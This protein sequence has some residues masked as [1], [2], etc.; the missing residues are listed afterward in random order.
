MDDP[1]VPELEDGAHSDGQILPFYVKWWNLT[2]P[3]SS[4]LR[5]KHY[6]ID[7]IV[8]RAVQVRFRCFEKQHTSYTD[9]PFGKIAHHMGQNIAHALAWGAFFRNCA[10]ACTKWRFWHPALLNAAP[11]LHTPVPGT[12]NHVRAGG[13]GRGH[14]TRPILREYGANQRSRRDTTITI[15]K[16]NSRHVI[17]GPHPPRYTMTCSHPHNRFAPPPTNMSGA[18]SLK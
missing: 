8:L 11:T 12:K 15:L 3:I 13:R 16:T 9:L 6:R 18:N 14:Q 4:I 5:H 17:G 7:E 10:V 2:V 1:I